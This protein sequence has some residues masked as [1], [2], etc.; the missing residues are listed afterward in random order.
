MT[1][2]Y[3]Y[4]SAEVDRAF[5]TARCIETYDGTSSGSM[6]Y[7]Y[8][9]SSNAFRLFDRLRVRTFSRGKVHI[10][11]WHDGNC[12]IDAAESFATTLTQFLGLDSNGQSPKGI[13]K[14]DGLFGESYCWYFDENHNILEDGE[15][16]SDVI[17]GVLLRLRK[18]SQMIKIMDFQRFPANGLLDAV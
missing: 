7:E 11:L 2:F 4:T 3:E 1:S 16:R 17:L 15:Y 9:L 6:V 13:S 5:K 18:S 14:T 12:S 8:A 10:G